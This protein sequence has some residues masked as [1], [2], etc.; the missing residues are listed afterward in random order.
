M[1]EGLNVD[2]EGDYD[3]VC[4][5]TVS[6]AVLQKLTEWSHHKDVPPP[7]KDNEKDE[8]MIGFHGNKNWK[9]TK[10]QFWT[11]IGSKLLR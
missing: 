6:A 7:P 2:E 9:L 5:P 1:L 8:L 10:E 4:L 11:D 3:P